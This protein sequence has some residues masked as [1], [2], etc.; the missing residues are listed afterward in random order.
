MGGEEFVIELWARIKPLVA[1]K[2]RLA[3]A[4][5]IISVCDEFGLADG[6]ESATD[7][8]KELSA[9]AKTY[10]G[11]DDDVEDEDDDYGW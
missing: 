5:A 4:D 10:Y 11:N 2:D 1:K 9:A 7:L 8:E 6:L 3:A